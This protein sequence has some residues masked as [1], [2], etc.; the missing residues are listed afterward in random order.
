MRKF[1]KPEDIAPIIEEINTLYTAE[2][3]PAALAALDCVAILQK[4]KSRDCIAL[5]APHKGGFFYYSETVRQLFK[6]LD[7]WTEAAETEPGE[8]YLWK[9]E[10]MDRIQDAIRMALIAKYGSQTEN[11]G[12]IRNHERI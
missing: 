3:H 2:K 7:D 9:L 6:E 12:R 5:R 1:Y 10:E 4:K 8:L 11:K